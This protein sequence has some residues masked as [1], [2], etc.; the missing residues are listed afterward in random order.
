MPPSRGNEQQVMAEESD[1]WVKPDVSE[2]NPESE[3]WLWMGVHRPPMPKAL[4]HHMTE[5]WGDHP[6][7]DATHPALH[8]MASR[9]DRLSELFTGKNLVIPS[10]TLKTRSN[11]TDYRFRPGSDFYWLAGGAQPDLVLVMRARD[12]GGHDATVYVEPRGDRS[13]HRFFSDPRY[14][15][16]WTGPRPGLEE[17]ARYLG[18]AT[19]PMHQL[20]DDLAAMKDTALLR[21][22]D[23]VVDAMVP[24]GDLDAALETELADLRLVKDDYEVERLQDAV[25]ATVRGFEDIV[26]AL[27]EAMEMGE[28]VIEG[29]FGLRARV[30]GNDTGYETIVAS[31]THATILHWNRNDGAVNSGDLLLVDAGVEGRDLYTADVTRTIPVSGRFSPEQRDVY[32]LVLAAQRAAIAEVRPGADFMDPHNAAMKVLAEGLHR[33]GILDVDPEFALRRDKQ[34]YRRYTLHGTSHMLG[35]DVHDC[36]AARDEHYATGKLRE[37]YVLTVEPGLYFQANDLTVPEKYR[38]IGVRIEDDVVVTADGCR[39]LSAGLPTDPDQI[40]TWMRDLGHNRAG[41]H[42]A[43]ILGSE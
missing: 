31:G 25:D 43:G 2:E 22:L 11:D 34:L 28:R 6:V 27:P 26:R 42:S 14:G 38:G 41:G 7:S 17:T 12:G 23:P 4:L 24:A 9:R 19:A 3:D 13:S 16:L 40:E 29:V 5:N 33:L 39:V 18:V 35:V 8:H 10:G 1:G 30:D 20:S 15:E 32:E 37:G 36:S 21:G